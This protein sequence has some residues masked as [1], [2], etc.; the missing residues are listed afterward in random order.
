MMTSIKMLPVLSISLCSES[1]EKGSVRREA[2]AFSPL[3]AFPSCSESEE[4]GSVA[5]LRVQ[6]FQSALISHKE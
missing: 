5:L 1:E 6:I 2:H 4:K 3:H